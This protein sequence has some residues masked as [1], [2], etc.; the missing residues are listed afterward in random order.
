MKIFCS[1]IGGIGLSAYASLQRQA[2][3][4]VSG[5]DRQVSPLLHDLQAQ[6]IVVS[7]MQD[8]GAVPAD[9]DLF[10]YSEAIPPENPERVAAGRYGIRTATYFEALG[11]FS[12]AYRVVAVAGAHGKSSTTAMTAQ[13]LVDADLDP[14][15]VVGTKV[16]FLDGRNWRQGKSDLFLVEACEYRR[17]FLHLH[18]SIALVTTVDGDH[19]DAFTSLEDYQQAF[20]EFLRLLPQDG[21]ALFHGGDADARRIV[22]ASGKSGI[23]VDVLAPP[24]L[25][26]PGAHMR[27]NAKLVLGLAD[28]LGIP[29]TQAASSLARFTGTWRRM[30]VKGT[31]PDGVT[32]VD[33]YG[34]HPAEIRA[35]LAAMREAYPGRRI[36]CVFQ[37]HTHDR[38][39]VLYDD[40]TRAFKGGADIVIIPNIYDARAFRDRA[41]ADPEKLAKDIAAASGI[42]ALYGTSLEST[43]TLLERE[44]LRS[45]DVLVC[46]GAGDVTTLAAAMMPA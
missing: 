19:F 30:E 16:P 7:L 9:A 35:T 34:H 15:V 42:S 46:M 31:R 29:R 2:G 27:E 3:H 39:L 4:D 22:D 21:I 6:G 38:T 5:S 25:G 45:G 26:I 40:F 24:R 18:P 1:G 41:Q 36:V 20:V 28:V 17:S 8:G 44:I 10:V 43:R 32:V 33:D 14:T 11:E 12:R 23:D 13:V 37:P